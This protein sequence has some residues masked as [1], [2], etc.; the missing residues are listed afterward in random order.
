MRYPILKIYT[1]K[2]V[3]NGQILIKECAKNGI[4]LWAVT[5]GMS[6]HREIALAFKK[7]GFHILADSRIS[8]IVKMKEAGIESKY[9]L[10]RIPMPSEIEDTVRL[11]DYSL[12]SELGS[13]L[14]MSRICDSLKKEHKIVIMIDMGDLREGFWPTEFEVLYEKLKNISSYLRIAGVGANFAC[15]SGALPGREN[16]TRLLEYRKEMENKLN[17]PIELVSGGGTCSL[18]QMIKGSLP[19]GVNSLRLG[20][21]ILLGTDS[22]VNFPFTMLSQDTM[23]IVAELCEVRVKP[24]H[25]IGEIGMDFSGNIPIFNDRGNRLRGVL[26]I[27]RQDVRIEG[28]LPLDEGVEIITASSDHLLVDLEDCPRRYKAGDK[29]R[30]R[31][32]YPAMLSASTSPFVKKI[33]S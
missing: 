9:A 15:A 25:P 33:F 30:F 18:V 10:I 14:E 4:S 19:E 23:E 21:S 16:L 13:I 17:R 20:E 26:G 29:L 24:T 32:D 11:C 1:E 28:L 7:A 27:G 3:E 31:P 6:A 5:K 2:I 22:S 8:N 12:I